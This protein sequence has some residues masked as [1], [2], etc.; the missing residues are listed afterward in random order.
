VGAREEAA[1]KRE[2]QGSEVEGPYFPTYEEVAS[3]LLD[4]LERAHLVVQG[5]GH[6]LEPSTGE[7]TFQCT[8][9]LPSSDP[10]YRYLATVHF[11]WDALLTYVGTYGPGSECDL[12]HEEEDACV[13][14]GAHPH[15][16]IELV[17]EYDLGDGS[18]EL[19]ELGEVQAWIDTVEGLLARALPA[20]EG[21][22]V[23]LGLAVRDG[24]IWVDRFV[25]EQSWY[26][27]LREAPE[28][29]PICSTIGATLKV[30]PALA[31]RLPL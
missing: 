30:T 8:V 14:H 1:V 9:R 26:L 4:A 24:G 27:D 5:V 31:D 16:G 15:P 23:H 20:Q 3:D 11:H 12:Y 2:G 10:P 7:R 29:G 19:R 6:E 28:L 18:Y 25:A 17:T 22:V 13:H 21:R